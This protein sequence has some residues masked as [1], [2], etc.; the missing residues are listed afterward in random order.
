M[1][2]DEPSNRELLF[3]S[4]NRVKVKEKVF[5]INYRRVSRVEVSIFMPMPVDQWRSE[6]VYRSRIILIIMQEAGTLPVHVGLLLHGNGP[7]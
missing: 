3:F 5:K 4:I 1:N 7:Q 2:S 6:V